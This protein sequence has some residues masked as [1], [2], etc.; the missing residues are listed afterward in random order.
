MKLKSIT[1]QN[2]KG[3]EKLTIFLDEKTTVNQKQ[4]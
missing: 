1:L 2:F 4:L 3:V